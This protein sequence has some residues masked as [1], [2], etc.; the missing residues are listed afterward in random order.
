MNLSSVG[1]SM[2]N[3]SI[4]I[5][6]ATAPNLGRANDVL[7]NWWL[8]AEEGQVKISVLDLVVEDEAKSSYRS[9]STYAF[10]IFEFR[11]DPTHHRIKRVRA[12]A[13]AL[14]TQDTL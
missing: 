7:P 11:S 12:F 1:E 9:D 14:F 8:P 10:Q 3:P 6:L 13:A 2:T 4:K 5:S